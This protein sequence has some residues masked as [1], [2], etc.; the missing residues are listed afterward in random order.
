[1]VVDNLFKYYFFNNTME[2]IIQYQKLN[3][4][5]P[6]YARLI[7]PIYKPSPAKIRLNESEIMLYYVGGG[8]YK[9]SVDEVT[10]G[11]EK[12]TVIETNWDY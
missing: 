10:G 9:T 5:K 7:E 2:K 11:D 4:I 3:R 8:M 12:I 6:K 1:M